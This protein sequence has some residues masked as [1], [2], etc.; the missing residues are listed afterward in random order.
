MKRAG[1]A[2]T[3]TFDAK[4]ALK[5]LGFKWDGEGKSWVA[6]FSKE[7]WEDPAH[8]EKIRHESVAR[9]P[10][11]GPVLG[12]RVLLETLGRR[13]LLRLLNSYTSNNHLQQFLQ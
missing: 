12:V 8:P 1:V 10:R 6:D 11:H 3:T 2:H 9:T 5:S 7:T 13:W 4:E